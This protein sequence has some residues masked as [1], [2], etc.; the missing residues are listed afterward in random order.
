M[1]KKTVISISI[2]IICLGTLGG[3]YYKI[4]NLVKKPVKV[5][6][7]QCSYAAYD[8]EAEM[9]D[10][11]D[12]I[13]YGFSVDKF[14]DRK[15][16]NKNSEGILSDFYAIAKFKIKRVIKNPTGLNIGKGDLFNVIEPLTFIDDEHGK[17]ILEIEGYAAMEKDN[18]YMIY[19]GNN[20]MG[21]YSVLNM[22]NGKFNMDNDSEDSDSRHLNMKK[23]ILISYSKV[24][25]N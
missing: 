14:E 10:A 3:V 6:S 15:H 19:L 2:F 17:R 7:L 1:K 9:N 18:N 5:I 22:A 8:S 16:V 25:S 4:H 20:G 24:L 23:D 11:S 21:G 13:L 12:I